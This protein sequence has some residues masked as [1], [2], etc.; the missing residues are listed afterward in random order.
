M[1]YQLLKDLPSRTCKWPIQETAGGRHLFSA[2]P[3]VD[4]PS[5][6]HARSAYCEEHARLAFRR[7]TSREQRDSRA[8]ERAG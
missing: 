4:T 2:E 7:V 3:I 1:T 6:G 8:L 5:H